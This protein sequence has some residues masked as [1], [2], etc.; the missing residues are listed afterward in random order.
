MVAASWSV[1]VIPFKISSSHVADVG[2]AVIDEAP[3]RCR[4]RRVRSH[5]RPTS[6]SCRA[7]LAGR[8]FCAMSSTITVHAPGSIAEA[9]ATAS[10]SRAR[11]GL[12]RNSQAWMSCSCVEMMP[13]T[14]IA[15]EHAPGIGR[16]AIGEDR[17]CGRA[18]GRGPL[19]ARS[20]GTIRS[21]AMSWTSARKSCG[22]T[23]CSRHQPGQ[24]RAMLVEM[25]L[26][27]APRLDRVAAEQALDVARP[28]AGRSGRTAGSTPGRAQ[29][30]RSK[31]QSRTW[32]KRGSM[33]MTAPLAA[34]CR[35]PA[36]RR[37]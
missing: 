6:W 26:L 9:A 32:A 29:L 15:V 16:V 27:D 11:S 36:K 18:A 33:A 22:S 1:M 23:S 28:C 7:L 34:F 12:G 21:S 13:S 10:H 3:G 17:I 37:T 8:R 2:D 19:R 35:P 5:C 4:D 30:S 20:S 24:R 25:A 31:I 14:P